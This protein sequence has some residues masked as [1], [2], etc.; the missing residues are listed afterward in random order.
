ME[1]AR[2]AGWSRLAPRQAGRRAQQ[3]CRAQRGYELGGDFGA[4]HQPEFGGGEAHRQVP[5]SG[6]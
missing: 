4:C 3:G 6:S 2:G 1:E 5:E